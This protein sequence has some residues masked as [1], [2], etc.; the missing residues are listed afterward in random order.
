[1]RP[2]IEL[3]LAIKCV[4][5]YADRWTKQTKYYI[6]IMKENGLRWKII[7]TVKREE[8]QEIISKTST[9]SNIVNNNS[10]VSVSKVNRETVL[11]S[12]PWNKLA[13]ITH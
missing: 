5:L 11:E 2:R 7:R 4:T 12:N 9:R 8:T 3:S 1:M 10:K 13:F 6:A